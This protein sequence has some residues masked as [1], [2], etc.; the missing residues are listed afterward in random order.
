MKKISIIILFSFFSKIYSQTNVGGVISINTTWTKT[1]SPYMVNS[2][3]TINSGI[4]L[5]VK[6]GVKVAFTGQFNL[7]VNGTLYAKGKADTMI[8]F[9]SNAFIPNAGQW[10]IINF[11][12]SSTAYNFGTHIGCILKNCK[13]MYG[14]YDPMGLGTGAISITNSAPYIDSCTI[15]NNQYSAVNIS[16]TLASTITNNLIMNNGFGGSINSGG[17]SLYSNGNNISDVSFNIFYKNDGN[18][19]FVFS[20]PSSIHNNVFVNN[21]NS[22][23][24]LILVDKKA[25]FAQN[26]VVDN[27]LGC[28]EIMYNRDT[29]RYNTITRNN[30]QGCISTIGNADSLA[31][32]HNNNLYGNTSGMAS[33]NYYEIANGVV[34]QYANSISTYAKN[35]WWGT[36]DTLKIDSLIRDYYD[37]TTRTKII[38]KPFHNSPDTTAPVTPPT[39]VCKTNLGG[40]S[41]KIAWNPNPEIDL[42]GYKVYWH[43]PT[44]YSF[45]NSVNVGNVT[46]YTLTGLSSS[47]TSIA[48]TAYDAQADGIKDQCE[49]HESWFT[50]SK[51][52]IVSGIEQ[53]MSNNQQIT[54]YPN[55]NNGNFIIET[56]ITEKQTLQVFDLNGRLVLSQNI[57]DKTEINAS[58][59]NEGIYNL[60]IKNSTGLANKKLIIIH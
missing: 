41:I 54:I 3:I 7:N 27:K 16:S 33:G 56:N 38:Y 5:T 24:E 49:G 9:T 18:P 19:A 17:I 31:E 28:G 13:I 39:K 6:P 26:Y 47:D 45:A 34:R 52:C 48:V 1:G 40:G 58:G 21:T 37:D 12:D 35:N 22:G 11:S 20:G 14:G 32:Y 15:S 57:S 43:L 51:A 4:T 36:I 23:A 59:L 50:Y 42:A 46:S 30:L 10:G 60:T 29:I 53:T 25:K 44:G 2:D 8:I 55:P